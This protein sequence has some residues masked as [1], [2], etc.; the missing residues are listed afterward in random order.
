[1]E[2][3]LEYSITKYSIATALL[4]SDSLCRIYK[5]QQLVNEDAVI[6]AVVVVYRGFCDNGE[7]HIN[8]QFTRLKEHD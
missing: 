4:W 5:R 2:C 3:L 1:M 6:G 7:K 8:K